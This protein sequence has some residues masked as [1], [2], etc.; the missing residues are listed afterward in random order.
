MLYYSSTR[1]ENTQISLII[2]TNAN[3]IKAVNDKWRD[4]PG[5]GGQGSLHD[6]N[7]K[8]DPNLFVKFRQKRL[9]KGQI[10]I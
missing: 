10:I 3:N 5:W 6:I 9:Y 4:H 7:P 1:A 8:L 2:I